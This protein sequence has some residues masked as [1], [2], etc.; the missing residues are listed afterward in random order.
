MR[1][2]FTLAEVLITLGIIGVVAALTMPTVINMAKNIVTLNK[3]KKAYST[4]SQAI[5]K[6]VETDSFDVIPFSDSDN[7]SIENWYKQMFGNNIRVLKYCVEEAGC[8]NDGTYNMNGTET[9]SNRGAIGLG[10][11]CLTFMTPD[12]YL[13]AL[14]G[15]GPSNLNDNFGVITDKDGL[16]I[17]IDING[18]QKPNTIG[19]DVFVYVY[20]MERGLIA[21]GKD[22]TNDEINTNC[23]KTD[24]GIFC[25]E[26]IIRDGWQMKY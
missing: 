10:G 21:A 25:S 7:A 22:L 26:K 24:N 9:Y 20:T 13:F 3:L 11:N 2:A 5:E 17:H 15:W 1:K 4:L 6:T 12:G 8:W 14:D 23:S 18:N 16:T 19:K